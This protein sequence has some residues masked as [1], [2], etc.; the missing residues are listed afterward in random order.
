[1]TREIKALR[2]TG[3]AGPLQAPPRGGA[4]RGSKSACADLDGQA[5]NACGVAWTKGSV[6]A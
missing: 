2:G 3:F 6:G 4:G 5:S 1:M